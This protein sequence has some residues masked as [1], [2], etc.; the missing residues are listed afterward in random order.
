M[1]HQDPFRA[2]VPAQPGGGGP[3]VV[4]ETG[5]GGPLIVTVLPVDQKQVAVPGELLQCGQQAVCDGA[6]RDKH[7]PPSSA[8][9][10][11]QRHAAGVDALH[12]L[13]R[14]RPQ[15]QPGR[16]VVKG[17]RK[18]QL[19]RSH[20]PQG[21]RQQRPHLAFRVQ[22]MTPGGIDVH[23]KSRLEQ[24]R[25]QGQAQQ[26]IRV[27]MAQQQ[28]D[29]ALFVLQQ[30][31]QLQQAGAGVQHHGLPRQPG[32]NADGGAAVTH[33]IRAADGNGASGSQDR[34]RRAVLH[35]PI[36]LP[37]RAGICSDSPI[38]YHIIS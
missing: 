4:A 21:R 33:K 32:Q 25:T 22:S 38:F 6:V 5:P 19:M 11:Q 15:F 30:T 31:R 26:V 27:G 28:G 36:I 8:G 18:G 14:D 24:K 37:F 10:P 23:P 29:P 16:Q 1:D 34:D 13:H 9:Q 3:C 20:G 12:A 7:H 35:F 17:R 2:A